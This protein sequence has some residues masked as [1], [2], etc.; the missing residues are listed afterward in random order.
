MSSSRHHSRR[1]AAMITVMVLMTILAA[2]VAS[3]IAISG[4]ERTRATISARGIQRQTCAEQG[5]QFARSYFANRQASWSTMLTNATVYNNADPITNR[6]TIVATARP[7][8]MDLDNDTKDDVYLYIR[9]N[10]D[11]ILPATADWTYDSDQAVII[12]AT[13]ISTTMV[14]RRP[15]GTIDADKVSVESILSFNAL[16]NTISSQSGQ[17]PSGSGNIN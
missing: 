6:A 14:P 8:V 5:L 9:D 7:L 3:V 10:D 11:E 13:C 4:A 1:G 15:N 17:G 2:I 12:G 16:I